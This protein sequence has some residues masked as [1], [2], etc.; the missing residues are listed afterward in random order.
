MHL[1]KPMAQSA[2][3][4]QKARGGLKGGQHDPLR[5]DPSSLGLNHH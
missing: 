1:Q 4:K 5:L 2:I 3:P